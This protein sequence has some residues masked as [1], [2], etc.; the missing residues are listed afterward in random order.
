MHTS[1]SS[2]RIVA[3][4]PALATVTNCAIT[5]ALNPLTHDACSIA[6]TLRTPSQSV[7][8]SS[9]HSRGRSM[10]PVHLDRE[11]AHPNRD[12]SSSIT[13]KTIVT[14]GTTRPKFG[15]KPLY[16]D[17]MPSFCEDLTKQSTMPE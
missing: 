13:I 10:W 8:A 12:L 6:Y 17:M 16:S 2:V 3:L 4:V 14:R 11:A 1:T 7:I 5:R 15:Q 9:S